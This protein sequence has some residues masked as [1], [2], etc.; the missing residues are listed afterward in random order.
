MSYLLIMSCILL[1]TN[2]SQENFLRIVVIGS[3]MRWCEW[4]CC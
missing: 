1:V 2:D 4:L 3:F